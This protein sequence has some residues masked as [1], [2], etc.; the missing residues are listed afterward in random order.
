MKRKKLVM[1]PLLLLVVVAVVF[2]LLADR[3]PAETDAFLKEIPAFSGNA[4]VILNGN[5]PDFTD[6]D[7]QKAQKG[8]SLKQQKT[9][10]EF[11]PQRWFFYTVSLLSGAGKESAKAVAK[12]SHRSL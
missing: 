3:K 11:E 7:L 12:R 9:T 10:A 4:F 5:Q 2:F 1:L 8:R 6:A